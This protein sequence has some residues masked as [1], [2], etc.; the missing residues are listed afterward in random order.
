[1]H[2]ICFG[3]PRLERK[4]VLHCPPQVSTHNTVWGRKQRKS[5][6]TAVSEEQ[7]K[8]QATISERTPRIS[9][10]HIYYEAEA[11]IWG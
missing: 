2:L 10:C 4:N 6:L 1:M 8:R 3:Q 11:R 9:F 5:F 7:N